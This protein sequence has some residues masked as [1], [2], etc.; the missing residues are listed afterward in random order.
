MYK[1]RKN[2]F[3]NNYEAFSGNKLIGELSTDI[4]NFDKNINWRDF[5][6]NKKPSIDGTELYIKNLYTD[7][8]YRNKGIATN[9]MKL[10]LQDAEE[11]GLTSALLYVEST[12]KP[13]IHLYKKI[14]F[15][16]TGKF[17]KTNRSKSNYIMRMD[18]THLKSGGAELW[19]N[20]TISNGKKSTQYSPRT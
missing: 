3:N 14:G 5:Y 11:K 8:E 7:P 13:A 6:N 1:L 20:L 15:K 9:L 4:W 18:I 17:N 2:K 12:Q 19:Q 16:I 10:A